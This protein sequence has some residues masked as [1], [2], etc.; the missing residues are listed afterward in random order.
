M[1]DSA[2]VGNTTLKEKSFLKYKGHGE[3]WS[4]IN[5]ELDAIDW[6][7]ENFSHDEFEKF[8]C[9]LLRHCNV[10]DVDV[11]PKR[12]SG[13]DGGLDGIG[14]FVPNGHE[15]KIAFEA[16]KYQPDAQIGT[17]VCQKLFGA[18]SDKHIRYG[19]LITT[20]KI[21]QRVQKLITN[22]ETN[23]NVYIHA[24]DRKEMARIMLEKGD[25]LQGLGLLKT[26]IGFVY[27]NKEILR[28]SIS[29]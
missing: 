28:Q 10:Y 19:F 22:Y 1:E 14:L 4:R 18:M 21:S 17:D 13:A 15:V 2:P 16:K 26:D 9:A 12:K 5:H 8:C 25:G 20:A 3:G 7:Y 6:I 24:I 27:M 29:S 11:T 23:Y